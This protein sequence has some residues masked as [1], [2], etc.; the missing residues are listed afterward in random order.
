MAVRGCQIKQHRVVVQYY[1]I[2][3]LKT[4]VSPLRL[5]A[6]ITLMRG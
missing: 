1:I 2:M 3:T 6:E 5:I 4:R